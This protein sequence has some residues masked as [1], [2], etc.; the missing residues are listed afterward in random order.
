VSVSKSLSCQKERDA[1][2]M[3]I[4]TWRLSHLDVY[5]QRVNCLFLE[6]GKGN[7]T[8]VFFKEQS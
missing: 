2:W 5:S 1:M 3:F 6:H 7:T 8:H 4:S